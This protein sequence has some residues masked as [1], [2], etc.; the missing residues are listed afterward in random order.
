M[1]V[2]R[3]NRW[4]RWLCAVA[5]L[6]VLAEASA[7]VQPNAA[8]IL[9]AQGRVSVVRHGESWAVFAGNSIRVGEVIETGVDGYAELQVA[10]GS[11]FEV[12]P[13][14]RVLFRSNPGNL[15]ELVEVFLGKIKVTIQHF[16]G[17]PNP[18]RVHSPT[19]VISVRGTVFEVGVENDAVTSVSVLEGLVTVAHRLLP[20][21]EVP[22]APG[23]YLQVFPNSP[24]AQSGASKAGVA[25]KVAG[26]IRDTIYSLPRTGGRSGGSAPGGGSGGGLP[27]DAS[28]PPPPPT[29]TD[30]EAPP[31]PP[32]Q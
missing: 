32:P 4:L 2:S 23:Q 19:A 10:D 15:R 1:V 13:S 5:A 18:Y 7:Q 24:L 6:V 25:A 3:H 29:P 26:A 14:S 22:L 30:R 8:R 11:T 21:K 28:A 17:R 16:G 20:G 31:P 9:T 27:T 12:F